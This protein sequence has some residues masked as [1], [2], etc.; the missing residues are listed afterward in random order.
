MSLAANFEVLIPGH[1]YDQSEEVA[2]H[3]DGGGN[4]PGKNPH[5]EGNANPRTPGDPV[6]LV[7][8]VCARED[9]QVDGLEGDVAVD[10]TGDDDLNML[11]F[12]GSMIDVRMATYSRQGDTV[13]NLGY[14]W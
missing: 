14:N 9:A 1:T 12:Q 10:D 6:T 8:A 2:E 5:G 7:H 13:C 4:N 3:R 11:V